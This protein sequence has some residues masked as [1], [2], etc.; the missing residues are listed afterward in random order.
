[1]EQ[2]V[3]ELDALKKDREED[4]KEMAKMAFGSGLCVVREVT[5]SLENS[6]IEQWRERNVSDLYRRQ[7]IKAGDKYNHMLNNHKDPE[8]SFDAD[9]VK[10]I[11]EIYHYLA[12]NKEQ[13]YLDEM[14]PADIFMEFENDQKNFLEDW[15]ELCYR[16]KK[17]EARKKV[18]TPHEGLFCP[19]CLHKLQKF[20]P[21]LCFACKGVI[22]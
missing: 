3:V 10:N 13:E 22:D 16:E 1:M 18:T 6:H 19:G 20:R 7:L 8:D 4:K 9:V 2:F 21:K 11:T 17:G 15:K 5:R 14:V 12:Q